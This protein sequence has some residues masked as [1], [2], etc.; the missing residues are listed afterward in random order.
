MFLLGIGLIA[1]FSHVSGT[2]P[3]M[4]Q[5]SGTVLVLEQW[6]HIVHR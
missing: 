4:E 3:V 6:L 2:V 1:D 5:V